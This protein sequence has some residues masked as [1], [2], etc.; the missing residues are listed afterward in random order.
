MD[1]AWGLRLAANEAAV[2][3]FAPYLQGRPTRIWSLEGKCTIG[4]VHGLCET[5]KIHK[6]FRITEA[7]KR[8]LI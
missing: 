8:R 7:P 1:W 6:S 2:P 4:R 5:Q 3:S